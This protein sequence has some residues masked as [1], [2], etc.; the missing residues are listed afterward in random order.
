MSIT[1]RFSKVYLIGQ[2]AVTGNKEKEGPMCNFYD[3]CFGDEKA[4]QDTFEDGESAM[5]KKA[6][7]LLLKKTKLKYEDIGLVFGGDLSNQL[8]SSSQCFKDVP[9]SFIG[10]YSACSTYILA[11]GLASSFIN[12][13]YVDNA[14]C[15]ASSNY[16]VC[17]RQF[18]YPLEYGI[19]KKNTTTV[20]V[21]GVGASIVSSFMSKIE[22]VSFTI[23]EVYDPTY[24]NVDDLGGVMAYSAFH[25]INSHLSKTNSKIEDYD[26]IVTGDLSSKGSM[27]LREM[28]KK[29]HKNLIN[30]CDA[31]EIVDNLEDKKTYAGGSGA[32]CIA[33]F[34]SFICTKMNKGEIKRCLLVGTGA[35]HSQTSTLQNKSIPTI[36]H[37]VELR[38]VS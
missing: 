33:I 35:L 5:I 13:K 22:V 26:L 24:N 18:R 36:S 11:L 15:Y 1:V 30:Y 34:M 9:L 20:T 38:R 7:T 12:A 17:E 31:G 3:F 29:D 4:H 16:G 32:G 21:S 14:L 2:V 23:G 27:V 25:V 10:L 6:L 37:A 8:S 19:C 28:F